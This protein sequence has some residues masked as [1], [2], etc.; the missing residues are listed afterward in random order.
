MEI[1]RLQIDAN[2]LTFTARAAGP[3]RGRPVILLHGFPQTSWSWRHV[4]LSL[5][6]EGFRAIAPDQRGYSTGARPP[7]VEDY[8]MPRLVSDVLAIAAT[9][10]MPIFDLVGHDWGGRVAWV[11]A[12]LNAER[13]R[14]LSIVSTPHPDALRIAR[15]GPDG[16]ERS[17]YLDLFRRAEEPE[18]LL[19]GPDGSGSG[20]RA[21]F[22]SAGVD[23]SLVD[24]YVATLIGPGALTA[25][26]NW[27]RADGVG[28]DRLPPVV[29]P[30]LYVWSTGDTALSRL[31]AETTAEFVAGRYVFAVMEGVSHWVPEQAPEELSRLLIEHLQTA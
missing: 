6:A 11:T 3:P 16:G 29:V 4:L 17:R 22:A 25:A 26:L 13:V 14:S 8:T 19:L 9:M 24:E 12:A 15:P 31:A 18:R 2:G 21:L 30:T 1:E 28:V 10:E 27:Y 5:G 20:I 7:A 23:A